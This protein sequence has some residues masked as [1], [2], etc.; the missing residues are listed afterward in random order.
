MEIKYIFNLG[1]LFE[2]VQLKPVFPDSKTFVDCTPKTDLNSIRERYNAEKNSIDFD[3]T[4]FVHEHFILPK[5]YATNY[6][7]NK[8]LPVSAHIESLWDVLTRK[9]EESHNS[10]IPLPHSYVVPGGR[11]REIYYWDSYFTML[12]LQISNRVD[13]LENMV[14]NFSDLIR[15]FGY[16]PNGN[17]TYYLDRSQPPFFAC[18][19]HLLS[20]EKGENTLVKYLPS[21][22][23]EYDFWMKGS[24]E[25]T[26]GNNCNRRVVIM[27]DG[28]ILNR[29]CD[30][31]E[32][33]RP[34]AYKEEIKWTKNVADKKTMYLNLRGA[35]ESGWD[36]SSRWYKHEND[37]SSIH[38][39]DIIPV[40]LNC[41]LHFL[42]QTIS[43]GYD[44]SGDSSGSVK[45][46]TLAAKRAEAINKYCWNEQK[47]F[48]F[49]YDRREDKQK[50]WLTLA[51]AFPLYFHLAS[52]EQAQRVTEILK[53]KFVCNGGLL[54]TLETTNQQWDAP[55][56]WAPLQWIAIKG[57]ANY[58]FTD[59]A[60]DISTKWMH[61]NEKV[62]EDTGK[63]MEKYNVVDTNLK[64]GG[65]EYPAQD[66]FGW[67]NGVFLALKKW[68]KEIG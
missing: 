52:R 11:F 29:Y 65:G 42:E 23:N 27:P 39:T 28:N 46:K 3:L 48:Y 51:A 9:P 63:M 20:E 40:D 67:T 68:M 55:N 50:D 26:K 8:Q 34:E 61:I 13:L 62:Y 57:L 33:P 35:C 6:K 32:F 18:M 36:F 64:A 53:E 30:G 44:L 7:S 66:G 19:V 31:N 60:K 4:A 2:K 24:D 49:D 38:T 17:R 14:D 22:Q 10:L 16:I 56:G 5:N 41:L 54:T 1:E 58:G 15:R 45:F 43:K 25:L 12:G 21:L 47:R 37:F 59:L